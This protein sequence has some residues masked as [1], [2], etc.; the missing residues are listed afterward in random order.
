MVKEMKKD[1]GLQQSLIKDR[2][3]AGSLSSSI[4]M[5][6]VS[7]S[8]LGSLSTWMK[9]YGMRDKVMTGKSYNCVKRGGIYSWGL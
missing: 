3:M 5:G 6:R 8:L 9:Y 2:N 4:E 7:P 1:I